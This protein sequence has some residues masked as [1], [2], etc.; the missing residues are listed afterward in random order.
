M[1][2][3]VGMSTDPIERIEYW[4]NLEGHTIGYVIASGLTYD[5]AAAKE[6]Y[7]ASVRGCHAA[8]GGPRDESR[9]WAV[10]FVSGGVI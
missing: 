2:C 4:K 1:A 5:E 7:E 9:D 3:R 8:P 10:Y 6:G